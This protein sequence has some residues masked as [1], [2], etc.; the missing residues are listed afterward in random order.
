MAFGSVPSVSSLGLYRQRR[1]LQKGPLAATLTGLC[2][3]V[4]GCGSVS[5]PLGGDEPRTTGSVGEPVRVEASLPE[6]L[7]YSDAAAIG[8]A[9]RGLD[10][11]SAA[12]PAD[13]TNA[14]TGSSGTVAALRATEARDEGEGACRDFDA[15]VHSLKGVHRY[16]A[17]ACRDAAG[18]LTL[19]SV[20]DGGRD[21]GVGGEA[22]GGGDGGSAG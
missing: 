3:L 22:D 4:A 8:A 20:R 6:T 19:R 16:A 14:A 18:G 17:T 15:T 10:L 5:M 21:G 12:E 1:A 11:A 13:W 7:A 2:L 9:A